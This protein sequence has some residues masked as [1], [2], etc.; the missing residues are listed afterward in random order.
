VAGTPTRSPCAGAPVAQPARRPVPASA[1]RGPSPRPP[2]C[3]WGC[4]RGGGRRAPVVCAEPTGDDHF[5]ARDPE[6][7]ASGHFTGMPTRSLHARGAGAPGESFQVPGLSGITRFAPRYARRP[8]PPAAG[9]GPSPRPPACGWGCARRG[10]RRGHDWRAGRAAGRLLHRDA[11]TRSARAWR[12]A[13]LPDGRSP[14]C[15][16]CCWPKIR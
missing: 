1:S 13:I 8:A 3:G 2:A 11:D 10:G 7:R 6:R 14:A 12:R 9:R 4:G 15:R 16:R 5:R